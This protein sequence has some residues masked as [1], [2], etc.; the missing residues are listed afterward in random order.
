MKFETLDLHKIR[1]ADVENTVCSFL[2][3]AEPPCRIIT[4]NSEKMK[5]IVKEIVKKYKYC[6]YNESMFNHGSLIIVEETAY[7]FE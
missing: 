1:H 3:W 5:A 6:C 4:G 7:D 2:N